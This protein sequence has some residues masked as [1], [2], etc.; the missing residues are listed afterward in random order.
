M[1]AEPVEATSVHLSTSSG[2]IDEAV[3]TGSLRRA[4]GKKM[5]SVRIGELTA[6]R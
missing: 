3:E 4:Q 1:R 6:R 2:R 5:R